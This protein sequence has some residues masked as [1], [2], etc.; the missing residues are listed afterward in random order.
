MAF[1]LA[2]DAR[3][4]LLL[5]LGNLVVV[6]IQA[7]SNGGGGNAADFGE[8]DEPRVGGA[9][10]ELKLVRLDERIELISCQGKSMVEDPERVDEARTRA[11]SESVNRFPP[12]NSYG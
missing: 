8:Q 11:H 9:G 1:P 4:V 2:V 3:A 7:S 10:T 6:E 12:R 5:P